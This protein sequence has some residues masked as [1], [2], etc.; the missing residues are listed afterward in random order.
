MRSVVSVQEYFAGVGRELCQ[1]YHRCLYY[2]LLYT[3]CGAAWP[4]LLLLGGSISIPLPTAM[5]LKVLSN[6]YRNLI[7]RHLVHCFNTY[8]ASTK[9][10]GTMSMFRRVDQVS[11]AQRAYRSPTWVNQKDDL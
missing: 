5:F 1:G 11:S 6:F 2:T 7:I 4:A 8:D 9:M 3:W 10:E